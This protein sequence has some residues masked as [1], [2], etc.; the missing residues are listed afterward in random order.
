MYT[1][2]KILCLSGILPFF[3]YGSVWAGPKLKLEENKA[4]QT[5]KRKSSDSSL[6]ENSK[7]QRR[8]EPK[9]EDY[10]KRPSQST[11]AVTSMLTANKEAEGRGRAKSQ[12]KLREPDVPIAPQGTTGLSVHV[13]GS[14]CPTPFRNENDPKKQTASVKA[15]S[16]SLAPAQTARNPEPEMNISFLKGTAAHLRAYSEHIDEAETEIILA[17]WNL[18]YIPEEIFSSLVRAKRRGVYISFVVNSVKREKTLDFF[19]DDEDEDSTFTLCE[20]KS[21]AKF[22]FVDKEC[23][24]LGSFNALGDAYEETEDASFTLEG[25]VRQLWPFYM[26]LYETYTSLGEDLG[27]IFD[28]IAMISKAR[29]SRP[30]NLLQRHFNDGSQIFLLRTVKE[31]EDFIRKATPY[32]GKVTIYSPFSTKDNTFKRLKTLEAI[33]P[34]GT[35]I[36]LKV[37]ERFKKGLT[38]LLAR[39]PL[40]Q[41]RAQV[42]VTD[43]HQKVITLGK[44]TLCV[45]SLNWLSAAQDEKNPYKR[46]ELSIVLQGP[47][48]ERVIRQYYRY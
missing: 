20:T 22:L 48:A 18:N 39:V 46:V 47:K 7:K 10:F 9:I 12:E 32:N 16:L 1:V 2:Q 40:L 23:L 19:E 4:H 8:G 21:H 17:S 31:H 43:S 13:K 5:I 41:N 30:R 45:G 42:D 25:S 34:V 29:Y 24:V 28:G 36:R 14:N 11:S 15:S 35:E 27:G 26:S 6:Q 37:L 38:N 3:M 44:E 33:V